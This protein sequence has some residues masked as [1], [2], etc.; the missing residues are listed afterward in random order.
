MSLLYVSLAL[1]TLLL[2]S[3]QD[4]KYQRVKHLT[5]LPLL[6]VSLVVLVLALA[7]GYRE[8][9]GNWFAGLV[10]ISMVDVLAGL[11]M[12]W[13]LR[14]KLGMGL[15]GADVM[16]L[17]C[18]SL[19]Y[20]IM[21]FFVLAVILVGLVGISLVALSKKFRGRRVPWIPFISAGYL[22]ALFVYGGIL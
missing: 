18:L 6:V 11:G 22:V 8:L 13:L 1:A 19:G 9:P 16:A 4:L 5:W 17:L 14:F 21:P 3:L 12:I 2:A 20:A 7:A 15:G 10:I